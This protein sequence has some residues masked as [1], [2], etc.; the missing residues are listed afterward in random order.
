M[1]ELLKISDLRTSFFTSYGQV[2]AVDGVS[3]SIKSGQT[4][5]LVRDSGKG[6]R[7]N[8]TLVML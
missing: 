5:G 1:T 6:I 4:M 7:G 2:C 8:T 3:F